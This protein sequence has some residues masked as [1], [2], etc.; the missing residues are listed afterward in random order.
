[1][2]SYGSFKPL[3]ELASSGFRGIPAKPGV[4]AVSWVR[5]GKPAP[6]PES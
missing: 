1:M 6:F 4:Y 2:E 3:K 5:D